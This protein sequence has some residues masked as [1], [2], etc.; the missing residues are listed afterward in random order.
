MKIPVS[1]SAH[2]GIFLKLREF[3]RTS[4]T[5]LARKSA[6]TVYSQSRKNV[7][8][9]GITNKAHASAYLVLLVMIAPSLHAKIHVLVMVRVPV[10]I[11]ANVHLDGQDLTAPS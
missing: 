2:S 5:T 11:S 3:A 4:G 8:T 1:L 6:E 9:T 7:R 10:P